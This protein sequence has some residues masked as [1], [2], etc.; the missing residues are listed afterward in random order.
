M[1]LLVTGGLGFIG[2]NFIKHIVENKE[3]EIIN[4]DAE[5]FGSSRSNLSEIKNL[6]N[7]EFVK[8][9]ITNRKLMEKLI[10]KSDVIINFAAQSHVAVSFKIEVYKKIFKELKLLLN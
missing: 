5:F 1:K 8:G 7:Y 2:S 4:V 3:I 9:N 6:D 10:S